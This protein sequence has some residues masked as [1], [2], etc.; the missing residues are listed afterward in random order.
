MSP[1]RELTMTRYQLT[2][3]AGNTGTL[4]FNNDNNASFGGAITGAGT[5]IMNATHV[6]GTNFFNTTTN[7]DLFTGTVDFT[8]IASPNGIRLV[9]GGSINTTAT[10]ALNNASLGT[11]N[12]GTIAIGM[13]T[14]TSQATIGGNQAAGTAASLTIFT[15]PVLSN[16][17]TLGSAMA[18]LAAEANAEIA[19]AAR[20]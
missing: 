2:V 4:F 17:N 9:P 13:I 15:K 3:N 20:P 6:T 5:L 10:F 1:D 7:Y 11:R 12:G 16:V 14:G 19:A 18:P 8:P